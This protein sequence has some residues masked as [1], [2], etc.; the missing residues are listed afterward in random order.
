MCHV[1]AIATCF[2]IESIVYQ[3][4]KFGTS[5]DKW[6]AIAYDAFFMV[7]LILNPTIISLNWKI[8]TQFTTK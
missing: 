4:I 6:L 8:Y 2:S 7:F 5:M 3:R 1:P